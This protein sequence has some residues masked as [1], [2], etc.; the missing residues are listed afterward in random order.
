MSLLDQHGRLLKGRHSFLH[1]K[2]RQTPAHC[3]KA[4][5]DKW[6]GQSA[7]RGYFFLNFHCAHDDYQ[8]SKKEEWH[9]WTHAQFACR[10]S[11]QTCSLRHGYHCWKDEFNPSRDLYLNLSTPQLR[12]GNRIKQQNAFKPDNLA[13]GKARKANFF[14][15]DSEKK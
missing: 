9:R 5:T 6:G 11:C 8:Y 13:S 15:E 14:Q 7:M 2:F 10:S 3:C 1:Q 4:R 12:T